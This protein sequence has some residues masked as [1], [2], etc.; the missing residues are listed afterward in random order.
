MR[1]LLRGVVVLALAWVLGYLPLQFFGE[2]GLVH[3]RRL[4]VE[5][6]ELTKRNATLAEEIRHMRLEVE[7]L[8]DDEAT[9]E[10]AAR[11]DLGMV[12][13]GELVFVL[14]E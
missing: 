3:Y 5:H 14:K 13:K 10:R 11:E 12:R 6:M 1:W 7:R 4:N 8:R 2:R 9:L